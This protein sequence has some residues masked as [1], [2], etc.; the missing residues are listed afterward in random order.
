MMKTTIHW[1]RRAIP[2][3]LSLVLVFLCACNHQEA[4]SAQSQH[5]EAAA[6]KVAVMTQAN[7]SGEVLNSPTPVLVD[8]WAAWCGPCR[9]IAPIVAELSVEYD[10]R[11]K[12]GKVDVDAQTELAEKYSITAIPAL[13]VFKDGKM[14]EQVVGLRSK[15]DLKGTLDKVLAAK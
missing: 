9:Q 6:G 1:S 12:F 13:L 7:F 4:G 11:V 8:F 5:G 3:G 14:V 15:K 2:L 10:G